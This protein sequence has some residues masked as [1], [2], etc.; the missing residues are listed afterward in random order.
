MNLIK[1]LVKKLAISI[2]NTAI[3]IFIF[4]WNIMA[5]INGFKTPDADWN[6]I[7]MYLICSVVILLIMWII[8]FL[9]FIRNFIII[10]LILLLVGWFYLPSLFPNVTDGMCVTMG[11]CKEGTEVK[12]ISGKVI[13]NQQNCVKQGW[14]WNSKKNVC[15]TRI[16][17]EDK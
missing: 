17:K 2:V 8:S 6:Q 14:T 7:F 13:I 9:K 11:S 3:T 5:I 10:I 15:E 16:K 4:Y 12:T 1:N